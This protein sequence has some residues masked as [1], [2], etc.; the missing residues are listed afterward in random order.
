VEIANLPAAEETRADAKG[1]ARLCPDFPFCHRVREEVTRNGIQRMAKADLSQKSNDF[2]AFRWHDVSQAWIGIRDNSLP[3][4]TTCSLLSIWGD[5]ERGSTQWLSRP[6]TRPLG[7][8]RQ[9]R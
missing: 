8:V 7:A 4:S 3:A 9:E 1:L 2:V 5:S 6:V